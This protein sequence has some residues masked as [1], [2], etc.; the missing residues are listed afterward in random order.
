MSDHHKHPESA[1]KYSTQQHPIQMFLRDPHVLSASLSSENDYKSHLHEP[2]MPEVAPLRLHKQKSHHEPD[3]FGN[4]AESSHH[5]HAEQH[6]N[7]HGPQVRQSRLPILRQVRSILNKPPPL[8]TGIVNTS[9]TPR[10][11][12]LDSKKSQVAKRPSRKSLR[13]AFEVRRHS[14]RRDRRNSPEVSPE[15]M[16]E[17]GDWEQTVT[18]GSEW[19][20]DI[21]EP[22]PVSALTTLPSWVNQ[23]RFSGPM[24]ASVNTVSSSDTR[25]FAEDSPSA[26][27]IK[28]KPAPRSISLSENMPP[29]GPPPVHSPPPSRGT[30]VGSINE[31][32]YRFQQKSHM[33]WSTFGTGTPLRPSFDVKSR[34]SVDRP[35][36]DAPRHMHSQDSDQPPASRF[37]W[38]TVNT[39]MTNHMRPDSPPPSPPPV[40][41]QKYKM[42]P[43]QSILSRHRPI[44]RLDRQEWTPQPRKSSITD[45]STPISARS[46][47]SLATNLVRSVSHESG[48]CTS[49]KKQ[50]PSPP[51]LMSPLTPMSHLETLLREEQDKLHQRRNVEHAIVDLEKVQRASPMDVS[52]AQVRDARNKLEELRATLEEIKLEERDIGIKV[53]RARRKE[54]D[55]ETGLWIRRVAG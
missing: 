40:M 26:S 13:G 42:P 46:K 20:G 49:A 29:Q 2:E 36:I 19:D 55:E 47:L 30:D 12:K 43:M 1:P 14:S 5:A 39:H 15:S 35:S 48:T 7:D 10:E 51:D 53:A 9:D 34:P 24:Q 23:D 32:E 18:P 52:F 25:D 44:Q 41:P 8:F 17:D 33:S 21:H 6:I 54:S 37:S 31:I 50:L 28:R 45:S 16:L 11:I 27:L 4:G 3:R 22:S 38:S